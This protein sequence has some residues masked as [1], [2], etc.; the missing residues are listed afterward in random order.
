VSI[1]RYFCP[2]CGTQ[3]NS[4]RCPQCGNDT[5][6]DETENF[7]VREQPATPYSVFDHAQY[8]NV[9]NLLVRRAAVQEHRRFTGEAPTGFGGL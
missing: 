6:Q 1:K 7:P 3:T 2:C 9:R 8:G 4:T 5:Q